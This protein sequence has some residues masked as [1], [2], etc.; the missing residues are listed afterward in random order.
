LT[1]QNGVP[2]FGSTIKAKQ[3]TVDDTDQLSFRMGPQRW[4]VVFIAMKLI[5]AR[6]IEPRQR[7][8][9]AARRLGSGGNGTGPCGDPYHSHWEYSNDQYKF[10]E[11]MAVLPMIFLAVIFEKLHHFLHHK[12]N[13]FDFANNSI[14]LFFLCL[15]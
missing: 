7:D 14:H 2:V 8:T 9:Q 12:V 13:M 11:C 3:K 15:I 1:I 4:V 6:S 5:P 10:V